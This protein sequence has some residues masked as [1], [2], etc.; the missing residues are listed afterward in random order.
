MNQTEKV[1]S[2]SMSTLVV[3][4]SGVSLWGILGAFLFHTSGNATLLSMTIG[5]ILSFI[6]VYIYLKFFNMEPGLSIAGKVKS[7]YGKLGMVA[8]IL[9]IV[10]ILVVYVFYTY[11]LTAFL[12]SQY[13]VGTVKI[14]FHII[15]LA[16]TFCIAKNGV[17]TLVRVSTISMF[18]C[19]FILAVNVF[20]L[21]PSID[22]N[23]FLP[24]FDAS[25]KNIM[26]SSFVFSIYFSSP[27][28]C[29]NVIKKNQLTDPEK[30]T[31]TYL[32]M[33][34]ISFLILFV[35]I[36]AV[37]GIY[38]VRLCQIFDYPLYTILKRINILSFIESL[39]NISIIIWILYIIITTSALLLTSINSIKE[40][41]NFK[42]NKILFPILFALTLFIPE[43]VY[44]SNRT[45]EMIQYIYIPLATKMLLVLFII[46]T[47][48]IHKIKK[49]KT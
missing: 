25:F 14:Y 48:I 36:T 30:F 46:L 39:E 40:V 18:I 1:N 41:F 10:L 22:I 17:G 45:I 28:I 15:I 5:F 7:V 9:F 3:A 12:S 37:L 11:R 2:F 43:N 32:K 21:Y 13:M 49:K 35:A 24:L 38:G 33:Y 23:N 19:F 16:I 8:N 6:I 31:K 47:L 26:L 20:A 27:T 42:S 44:Q 29:I 34:A 4:S